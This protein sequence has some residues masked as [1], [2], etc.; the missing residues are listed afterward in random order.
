MSLPGRALLQP[1]LLHPD[2]HQNLTADLENMVSWDTA[3]GR[4]SQTLILVLLRVLWYTGMMAIIIKHDP[5]S[6]LDSQSLCGAR[7]CVSSG[8]EAPFFFLGLRGMV[9]RHQ[10]NRALAHGLHFFLPSLLCQF[11]ANF[12]VHKMHA[13]NVVSHGLNRHNLDLHACGGKRT[14]R[15]CSRWFEEVFSTNW[16]RCSRLE[17]SSWLQTP[18]Y[19]ILHHSANVFW[20]SLRTQEVHI[21]SRKA[22]A[23]LASPGIGSALSSL[24]WLN[25][26]QEARLVQ[27]NNWD[28]SIW[29]QL[30]SFSFVWLSSTL[31]GGWPAALPLWWG[32]KKCQSWLRSFMSSSLAIFS[33]PRYLR[34]NN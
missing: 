22:L 15:A 33:V 3:A 6:C 25:C 26:D 8:G 14:S 21:Q 4:L 24:R 19:H 20:P 16:W 11:N 5:T 23:R 32:V 1:F 17:S 27:I 9:S 30:K 34:G 7:V 29:R 10:W 2:K 13:C 18:T 28:S 12:Q 31:S